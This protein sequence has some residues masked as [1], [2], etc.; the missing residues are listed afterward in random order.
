MIFWILIWLCFIV[1]FVALVYPIVPGL[2]FMIGGF[3]LYGLFFTFKEL[4][5]PF[6][7]VEGLFIILL[8]V[9][10]YLSNWFG[11]KR[12]GGTKAGIWGST[13]GLI[14]G[15][16]VIPFVGIIIGPFVG[17]VIAELLVHRKSIGT[18]LKIGLGSLVAFITSLFA[19]GLIQ[20]GMI[21]YFLWMIK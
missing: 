15:P 3:L 8:I 10:D 19:K 18:S 14:V 5:W 16:F 1:A 2:L 13:I 7:V 9:A 11:I 12:F 4:T 17:A 21:A 20:V 6:W